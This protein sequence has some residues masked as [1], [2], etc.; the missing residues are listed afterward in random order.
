[1]SPYITINTKLDERDFIYRL[2]CITEK[3]SEVASKIYTINNIQDGEDSLEIIPKN[4]NGNKNL[5]LLVYN[6]NDCKEKVF[7]D[8]T[9]ESWKIE[10]ATYDLYS[11][12]AKRILLPILKS[13][14]KKYKVQLRLCIQSKN[15]LRV[16]LPKLAN[17]F[18]LRF[19][20]KIYSKKLHPTDLKRFYFFVLHCHSRNVKLKYNDLYRLLIENSID[21]KLSSI[22]SE[23]YRIIREFLQIVKNR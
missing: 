4:T 6:L 19:T 13:Y 2:N 20:K 5:D 7:I 14:N 17:D 18:F 15:N 9:A 3:N 1:M 8:L 12:E 10:P 22:L 21:E 11:N 23:R 16:K